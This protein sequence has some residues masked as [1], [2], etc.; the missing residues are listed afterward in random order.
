MV[1]RCRSPYPSCLRLVSC[2]TIGMY[3]YT[4]SILHR[5]YQYVFV[6]FNITAFLANIQY[7]SF[8]L[9]YT[10]CGG[11]R[12]VDEESSGRRIRRHR[13]AVDEESSG[14]RIRRRRRQHRYVVH[15][16]QTGQHTISSIQSLLLSPTASAADEERTKSSG[17]DA[18]DEQSSGRHSGQRIRRCSKSSGSKTL[19]RW[20]LTVKD[21]NGKRGE[22]N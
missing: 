17:Q 16:S 9:S 1:L 3:I 4:S 7:I 14:R 15:P 10:E 20:L 5:S 13:R 21:F 19:V 11:R 18:T 6:I 8:T 12:A 2:V 22:Q